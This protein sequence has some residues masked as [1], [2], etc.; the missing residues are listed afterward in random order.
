MRAGSPAPADEAGPADWQARGSPAPADEAGWSGAALRQ[1]SPPTPLPPLA[2]LRRRIA[3]TFGPPSFAADFE[4][5][6]EA[7]GERAIFWDLLVPY[8]IFRPPNAIHQQVMQAYREYVY[9]SWRWRLRLVMIGF[10]GWVT[11]WTIDHVMMGEYWSG[12][13]GNSLR[14]P[15]IDDAGDTRLVWVVECSLYPLAT[16]A[17]LLW[18]F[19]P[20][21]TPNNTA[22]SW[23]VG[24]VCLMLS[25]QLPLL[26]ET[27]LLDDEEFARFVPVRA[28]C[29]EC[30]DEKATA[31]DT[32]AYATT[33][34]THI[35][36]IAALPLPPIVTCGLCVLSTVLHNARYNVMWHALHSGHE[37]HPDPPFTVWKHT[38]PVL[39]AM[40]LVAFTRA[41]LSRQSFALVTLQRHRRDRRVE[42]LLGE[43]ERLEY[44][45]SFA[46]ADASRANAKA[47]VSSDGGSYDGAADAVGGRAAA[48]G[49]VPGSSESFKRR[50]KRPGPAS[51]SGYG[52]ETLSY[53]TEAEL[54]ELQSKAD[55]G[56][57]RRPPRRRR[58]RCARFGAARRPAE[59][60]HDHEPAGAE[61]P[62]APTTNTDSSNEAAASDAA[63]AAAPA[64]ATAEL[65]AVELAV[66]SS[67]PA[68]FDSSPPSKALR[69]A[70]TPAAADTPP[71]PRWDLP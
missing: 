14:L 33:V 26:I 66:L 54:R 9:Q 70:G 50:F 6:V 68:I 37:G 35:V 23:T 11:L 53:G 2:A 8:H 55:A 48:A 1:R 28:G 13:L 5:E 46:L 24:I 30:D 12:I 40:W 29:V 21:W 3:S 56:P 22:V 31:F 32:I 41:R 65:A 39:L 51:S 62:P 60:A 19:C 42:Q 36:V 58:R 52:S 20:F 38:P 17:L 69:V 15:S 59:A 61:P 45:R 49:G 57:P 63:P 44:E 67:G 25:F 47:A 10:T 71:Q 43:K 18:S 7:F 4:A 34:D 16:A 27:L 64:P